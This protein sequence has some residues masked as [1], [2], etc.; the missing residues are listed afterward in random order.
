LPQINANQRRLILL[1][2]PLCVFV[3][4]IE[5]K[6]ELKLRLICVD[7]PA[8]PDDI[9]VEFGLQDKQQALHAGAALPNG[10]LQFDFMVNVQT[11]GVLKFSGPFAQGTADAPF[12]YLGLRPRQAGA[13]WIKRIKVPL[14][15]ITPAQ[16]DAAIEANKPL[17]ARVSGQRSGTVPLLKGWT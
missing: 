8:L 17:Q 13:A 7:P 5:M 16:V 6:R 11:D 4:G 1:C 15:A 2:V 14:K 10:A 12:V 9:T 3:N